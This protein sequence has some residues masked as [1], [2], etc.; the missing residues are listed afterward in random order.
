MNGY[1]VHFFAPTGL[2]KGQKTVAFVLDKSGS[3]Y[4][5][6]FQQTQVKAIVL[7]LWHFELE[8]MT[9]VSFVG[10]YKNHFKAIERK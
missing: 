7:G 2:P 4:G 10:C 6:K 8:I 9:S 5:R 3:M 1:F